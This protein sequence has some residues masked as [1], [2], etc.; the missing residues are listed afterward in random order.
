M[1]AVKTRA[2]ALPLA[3]SPW[4]TSSWTMEVIAQLFQPVPMD[5]CRQIEEAE[6]C[7]RLKILVLSVKLGALPIAWPRMVSWGSS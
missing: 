7:G 2:I 1:S 3:Q 6:V 4:F 5:V